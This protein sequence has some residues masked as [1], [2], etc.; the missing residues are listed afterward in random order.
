MRQA[1]STTQPLDNPIEIQEKPRM[2]KSMSSKDISAWWNLVAFFKANRSASGRN[3]SDSTDSEA[4]L[5]NDADEDEDSF[6]FKLPKESPKMPTRPARPTLL[7]RHISWAPD[8][9]KPPKAPQ[10][11]VIIT[12]YDAEKRSVSP[13]D[14]G[15][16][17]Y[18]QASSDRSL[19]SPKSTKTRRR[20]APSPYPRPD[21]YPSSSPSQEVLEGLTPRTNA[22]SITPIKRRGKTRHE[23]DENDN[24]FLK[25]PSRT[26]ASR[27][28]RSRTPTS[29]VKTPRT[30]EE[31]SPN[32][33]CPD[34]LRPDIRTVQDWLDTDPS[35]T[36]SGLVVPGVEFARLQ[37]KIRTGVDG[38][39]F[40]SSVRPPRGR[41]AGRGHP[42]YAP[43]ISPA[44][45]YHFCEAQLEAWDVN[46][47]DLRGLLLEVQRERDRFSG[48]RQSRSKEWGKGRREAAIR[49]RKGRGHVRGKS[50][51]QSSDIAKRG[52]WSWKAEKAGTAWDVSYY[53]D[54]FGGHLG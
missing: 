1:L 39:R 47:R 48:Q 19:S 46:P 49:L 15:S 5:V 25:P 12:D 32:C 50:A 53:D 22:A 40:A 18:Q 11:A 17:L 2:E 43:S 4:T 28:S 35:R 29:R 20:R 38:T 14:L 3:R 30:L 9:Q 54:M 31:Q 36:E 51:G 44:P 37:W 34:C 8:P 23:E 33:F 16:P 42:D 52:S 10:V 7:Q 41:T 6:L 26:S 27:P 24:T 21:T 13:L 45:G